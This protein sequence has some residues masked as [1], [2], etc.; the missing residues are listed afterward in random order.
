MPGPKKVASTLDVFVLALVA[1]GTDTLYALKREA[2]LSVGA[3][4]PAIRRLARAGRLKR[5][6]ADNT[7]GRQPL[8]ITDKGRRWVKTNS[9]ELIRA[10]IRQP[11]KDLESVVRLAVLAMTT[12]HRAMV[13]PLLQAALAAHYPAKSP[14]RGT[15]SPIRTAAG[16]YHSVL[17]EWQ[18]RVD[19]VKAKFLKDLAKLLLRPSGLR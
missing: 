18:R 15:R 4:T 14:K 1:E 10:G 11:P 5:A 13:A 2:G 12:G 16:T 6:G 7:R 17:A 8:A 9:T 3:T 19:L